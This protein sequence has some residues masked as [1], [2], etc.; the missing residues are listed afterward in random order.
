MKPMLAGKVPGNLSIKFPVFAS[1]KIDGIRC[2]VNNNIPLTRTLKPIPNDFIRNQIKKY[3]VNSIDGEIVVGSASDKNVMQRTSSGVMSKDGEPDFTFWVFDY[4]TRPL[5]PYHERLSDLEM[6]FKSNNGFRGNIRLLKHVLINSVEELLGY[7]KQCLEQGFEG[8]MVRSLDGLYKY[9]RSTVKEGYLLKLK[10]FEDA[11]AI[12]I[13]AEEL[14]HNNNE[15]TR[16]EL[17][18]AKRSS[19]AAGKVGSGMLGALKVRD[20]TTG[21]EF[22][23]GTGFTEQQRI[24]FWEMFNRETLCSRLVKYKHFAASGVLEAPRFPVFLGFRDQIDI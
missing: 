8:V 22:N 19:C 18:Y 12:I 21:I 23:I 2:V 9:G 10:R 13:G 15:L 4:H 6:Y 14:F 7:E 11:E 17:G 1:P 24:D 16:D 3:C 5:K 20:I